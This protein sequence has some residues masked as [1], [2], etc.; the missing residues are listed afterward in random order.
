MGAAFGSVYQ[1][2]DGLWAASVSN[3]YDGAGKRVRVTV[4]APTKAE[5][6]RKLDAARN[7]TLPRSGGVTVG[8]FVRAWLDGLKASVEPTTWAQYDSHLRNHIDRHVGGVRLAALDGAGVAG[9]VGRLGKARVSA[10]T[11]RKVARTLRAALRAAVTAGVIPKDPSARVPL[12]KHVRPPVRVLTPDEVRVLMAAAASYRLETLFRAAIDSGLR[13]GELFALRWG[14]Y[15]PAAGALTVTKAMAELN[16]KL[17]EK[18]AKTANSRRRVILDFSRPAL[19]AHRQQMAAEGQDTGP[20]GLIFPDTKGKPLRKSNF[21]RRAFHPIRERAG[22][23][24]L[25]FHHLRHCSASLMLLAGQD[26]KVVSSRLGHSSVG[27]TASTYQHV[28]AGLQERAA[29][30]LADVLNEPNGYSP[31]TKSPRKAARHQT[32]KPR[33]S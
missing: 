28:I 4:Y 9:F 3:G 33:K 12:P 27:F 24:E 5:V 2:G 29:A 7:G 20:G 30:A 21:A 13:Q 23:P 18:G 8:Q 14:D 10:A 22:L 32:K 15:D 25:E 19:D 16:G 1:R 31:A 26:S 17:W 6:M 11:T